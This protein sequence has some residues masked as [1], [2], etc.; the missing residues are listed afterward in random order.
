MV[1]G[2]ATGMRELATAESENSEG[3][4]REGGLR[5][6]PRPQRQSCTLELTKACSRPA[7]FF[8]S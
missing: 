7:Y 8:W 2:T 4:W 3:H 5:K 6:R 1:R